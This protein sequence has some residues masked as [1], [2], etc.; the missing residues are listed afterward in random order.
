[1]ALLPWQS[2]GLQNSLQWMGLKNT[3]EKSGICQD[4]GWNTKQKEKKRAE[5]QR[6]SLAAHLLFPKPSPG[7]ALTFPVTGKKRAMVVV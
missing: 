6:D 5:K 4:L 3:Q 1:M 2:C 7:F